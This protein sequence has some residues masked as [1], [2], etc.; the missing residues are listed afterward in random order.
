MTYCLRA[1][2]A[3]GLLA[4]TLAVG[5][6]GTAT[7]PEAEVDQEFAAAAIAGT[8]PLM[9]GS[10][11]AGV[12]AAVT[13]CFMSL[14][15]GTV[16]V[17]SVIVVGAVTW[18]SVRPASVR[19]APNGQILFP[20]WL[21][22]GTACPAI[23]RS[24]WFPI[25]N[26]RFARCRSGGGGGGCA[27]RTVNEAAYLVRQNQS[28]RDAH[29]GSGCGTPAW[30]TAKMAAV[31]AIPQV[32]EHDRVIP[33]SAKDLLSQIDALNTSARSAYECREANGNKH[34]NVESAWSAMRQL[35]AT[36]RS[37]GLPLNQ[38]VNIVTQAADLLEQTRDPECG[39]FEDALMAAIR[40]TVCA[41]HDIFRNVAGKPGGAVVTSRAAMQARFD[42]RP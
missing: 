7:E 14:G 11:A 32:P 26:D 16:V 40:R 37:N 22:T 6:A 38:V 30:A 9:A 31:D 13:A 28:C 29:G 1:I 21:A 27:T 15:C 41:F 19:E 20:G 8:F 5:C 25:L 4:A 24:D 3:A 34:R 12:G 36:A 35:L 18:V 42:C 2:S 33:E 17:L 23:P 39:A 10:E